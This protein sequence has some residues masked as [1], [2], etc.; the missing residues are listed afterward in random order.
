LNTVFGVNLSK[1]TGSF[2]EK[3]YDW[4]AVP[5]YDRNSFTAFAQADYRPISR[6]KL[7]AGGQ[8]IKVPGFSSHV[9]GGQSAT[10]SAIP[11]IV[12][13]FAGRL[14]AVVTITRNVTTKLLYSEA[15]RQPSVVE[16]DRVRFD[17][18]EYTQE[19]NPDLQPEEISTTDLQVSY[20]DDR[21]PAIE[22]RRR[23]R[24]FRPH[25]ELRSVPDSR[26]RGRGSCAAVDEC[27]TDVRDDVSE[28]GSRHTQRLQRPRDSRAPVHGKV[29]DVVSDGVRPDGGPARLLLRHPERGHHSR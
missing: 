24:L 20:G 22:C 13:H 2:Y 29:R 23:D 10:V 11:G 25:R 19:G 3:T 28:A 9:N 7:I 18:G 8:A 27:G 16:T 12:P 17:D 26:D 4:Y 5:S 14:G 1:R 21:Q 15:F 6:L